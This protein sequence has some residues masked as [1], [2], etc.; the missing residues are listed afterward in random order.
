MRMWRNILLC[1]TLMLL[2]LLA[3]CERRPLVDPDS[4][5]IFRVRLMTDSIP[6][7]T[8]HIYNDKIERPNISTDVMRV[9][10]YDPASK[11]L[12]SQGF[13]RNKERDTQGYEVI[14]GNM[15]LSHG[16]YQILSY[17]FDIPNTF[18]DNEGSSQTI[19]AYTSEISQ[20]HYA[21]LESR[22]DDFDH[23]YYEPDHLF[24]ARNMN[25]RIDPHLGVRVIE[26]DA[27]PIIDTYE[28]SQRGGCL[29]LVL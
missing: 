28:Y 27:R 15:K 23:I 6:N 5:A 16:D 2:C 13:I 14:S 8:C 1:T 29:S 9:L 11:E 21:C 17:N 22:A 25:V 7:V 4:S 26:A 12:L 3:G 19:R 18:I 10:V 20:Y 24:V